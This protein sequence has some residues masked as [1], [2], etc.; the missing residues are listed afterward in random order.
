MVTAVQVASAVLVAVALGPSH[1]DIAHFPDSGQ[2]RIWPAGT[3]AVG[4]TVGVTV[5]DGVGDGVA[6]AVGDVVGDGEGDG[7]GLGDGVT[8][9]VGHTS[10]TAIVPVV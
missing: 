1:T 5:G 2:L 4:V 8:V 3:V 9:G 10:S 6:V 7:E